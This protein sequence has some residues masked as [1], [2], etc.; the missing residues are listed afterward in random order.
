AS[1]LILPAFL[2]ISLVVG[3]PLVYSLWMSF[4]DVNLL[5]TTGPALE[6]SGLRIPFFRYVG[7]QNYAR[8]LADPL[9]WDSFW[10][11]AYFVGAFVARGDA[12]HSH[13]ALHGGRGGRC[14][15]LA[16]LTLRDAAGLARDSLP[17]PGRVHGQRVPHARPD[18]HADDGRARQ[19]DDD[20]LVARLP[21]S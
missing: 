18:L 8:L 9:Y 20:D 2:V 15:L 6:I 19:R 16:A 14:R 1:I 11:T 4:A 5:R 12:I 10:R 13:G 21:D 17:R 3:F 7:V